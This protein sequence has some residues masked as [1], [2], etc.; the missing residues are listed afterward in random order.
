MRTSPIS[1]GI[2]YLSMGILFTYLAVNSS[3]EGLWSFPTI[4]LML[5]ATFDLGVALRMFN[6]SFKKK[7]K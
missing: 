3:G 5:I 2:F 1:M 7:K 4:L 6:L